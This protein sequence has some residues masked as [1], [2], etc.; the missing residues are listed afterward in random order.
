MRDVPRKQSYTRLVWNQYRRDPVAIVGLVFVLILF[1][2]ALG[3]PFLAGSRPIV[4]VVGHKLVFPA[5]TT[6]ARLAWEA[7]LG[8]G[9]YYPAGLDPLPA[10]QVRSHRDRPVS[11]PGTARRRALAGHR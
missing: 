10:R 7:G 5:V 3:A 11:E 6:K 8:S 9:R 1:I 4:A 2:V